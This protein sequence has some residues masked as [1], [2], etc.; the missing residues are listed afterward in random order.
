MPDKMTCGR[1][2][3]KAL[4]IRPTC[5]ELGIFFHPMN[6][7]GSAVPIANPIKTRGVADVLATSP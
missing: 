1:L 3:T 7:L 2:A 4:D 6:A 5:P